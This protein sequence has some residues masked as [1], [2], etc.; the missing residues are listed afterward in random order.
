MSDTTAAQDL[1]M[2]RIFDAPRELVYRAFTDPDQLA[3]WFGPIGWS[4]PRDSVSVDTRVGGYQ[5]FVMVN[6]DDASQSSPVDSMFTEVVEN[7]LLVGYE[8]VTGIPGFGD[9]TRFEVRREFH[10]EGDKTR[11]VL[12]QGPYTAEMEDNAREGWGSSFTKLDALLAR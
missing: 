12:R 11:L 10:D 8:D 6:D 7:E 9:A 3:Q 5:R 1:V 2:T 4:V